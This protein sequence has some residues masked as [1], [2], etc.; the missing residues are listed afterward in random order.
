M[1]GRRERDEPLATMRSVVEIVA[2]VAAGFW[3]LYVFAYEQR[4]KPASEPP[5]AAPI[6][7]G[8]E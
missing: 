6:S 1:F 5:E 3:A 4:S 8:D 2:I 7:G